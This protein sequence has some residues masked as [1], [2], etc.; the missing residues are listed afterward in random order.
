MTVVA[1]LVQV[2]LSLAA[3]SD[4]AL[5]PAAAVRG[6]KR[7]WAAVI[8]VNFVGPIAYFRFGRIDSDVASGHR[9]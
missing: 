8:A 6:R 7:V 9:A 4:L 2:A 5:R 1:G 3:W